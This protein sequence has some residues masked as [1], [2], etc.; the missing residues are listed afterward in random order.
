MNILVIEDDS[1]VAEFMRRVLCKA[2]HHVTI[3]NDGDSGY[4]KARR[5]VYDAII[6]DL[7]LPGRDGIGLCSD[8]RRLKVTTPIVMLTSDA[9]EHTKVAGLD[10]GAD[11]YMVKPF[12]HAELAARLRA[13]TRRPSH[14]V[15]SKLQVGDLQL[16]PDGHV[17]LRGSKAIK[18]SPKEYELI[19]FMMQNPGITLPRHLILNKVWHVY[20]QASSNRLEVCIRQLRIKLG[21]PRETKVIQT[22]HGI[23]YKLDA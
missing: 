15:Q 2:G 13:V 18:L 5:G 14:I 7:Y 4:K 17:V 20:S 11:D 8:L 21:G 1:I 16:D 22:V 23:G 9:H 19:E 12:S 6:L 10:A 3:A